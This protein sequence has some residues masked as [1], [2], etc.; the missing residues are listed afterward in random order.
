MKN[1]EKKKNFL[2]KILKKKDFVEDKNSRGLS[3]FY[4]GKNGKALVDNSLKM[5]MKNISSLLN[6]NIRINLHNNPG[7][8]YHDMIILQRKKT[9]Y[10]VHKHPVGGETIHMIEGKIEVVFFTSS[11]KIKKTLNMDTKN[12]VIYRVPPNL[13]HT[14]KILSNVA[15]F[16]ENKDGPYIRK[17]NLV[18]FK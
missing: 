12:N 15:I 18:F 9:N 17:K 14:Y 13:F 7:E 5:T 4:K 11:G 16:H 1:K 10:P 3:F 6:E 2:F 8:K